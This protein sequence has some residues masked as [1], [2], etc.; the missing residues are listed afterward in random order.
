MKSV[1]KNI[2]LFKSGDRYIHYTKHGGINTG[3]V[4]KII[5]EKVIT[6]LPDQTTIHYI[7]YSIIN[8]SGIIYDIDG[9]DGQ[10]FKIS[11]L[12]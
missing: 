1:S 4:R 8:E 6:I 2:P 12:L 11:Y 10:F 5:T 9:T 7:R 3:I